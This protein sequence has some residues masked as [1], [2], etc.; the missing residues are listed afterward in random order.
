MPTQGLDEESI[1]NV[2]RKIDSA[3]LRSE[4][5]C[6]VCGRDEGLRNRVEALLRVLDQQ[7]GFLAFPMP[8]PISRI[9]PPLTE[10]PGSVVGPYKLLEQIGEGGF[11][12]VFMAEQTE[13]VRR[14]VALK[15]LKPGMDTRQIVARFEAERQALAIMDHP[16]IA[17]VFDGGETASGRPFFVMELVKGVPITDYCDQ[18]HLTPRERLQLFISVC[19]AVQ[20]AHQK[21]VIH[22]DL[23]ASNVLVAVHDVMPVVKVI[24]FGIAKAIGQ[25]LTEKTLFTGFAHL[26]GTPACMSPEQ[27]GMS[28]LDVDTRSDIYSL[29]VLLYELLTGTTPFDKDRLQHASFDEIRRIIREVEPPN[30]STRLTTLGHADLNTMAQRCSV[31]PR[32]LSQQVRG[33]LDWIV[34]KCLEKDRNRRY[35]TANGLVRDIENY[36]ADQPV[37]ACPP[38]AWYRLRKLAYR[39]KVALTTAALVATTLMLGTSISTWQAIRA[40]RAE[41]LAASR[42]LAE[43]KSRHAAEIAGTAALRESNRATL[44]LFQAK[45]E[46]AK[47]SRR[48]RTI[49]QRF[50]SWRA[51][52]EAAD[53]ARELKMRE[54]HLAELRDE[55]IACLALADLR[56]ARAPWEGL[57]AGSSAGV[58]FDE[59]LERYARSDGQGNVSVRRVADDVELARLPGDHGAAR[60]AFSPSGESLAVICWSP[61]P[62]PNTTFCLWDWQHSRAIFKPSTFVRAMDFSPDGLFIALV[63]LDGTL[64]IH[65]AANGDE[66]FNANLGLEPFK[67]A[68]SFDGSRIAILS[69]AGDVQIRDVGTGKLLRT[70][71]LPAEV[72]HVAWH[73]DGTML[74]AASEDSNVYLLD[75]ATGQRRGV[76]Q[77]HQTTVVDVSFAPGGDMLCTSS[78]DGTTRLWNVWTGREQLRFPGSSLGFSRDGRRLASQTGYD[79]NLWDVALGREYRTLRDSHHPRIHGGGISP[80]GRWLAVAQGGDFRLW[81]LSAGKVTNIYSESAA[82]SAQFHPSG[83]ELFTS[84]SEGLYRWPVRTEAGA[85]RIGPASRLPVAGRTG[86]V[87]LD[88]DGLILATAASHGAWVF[89][90]A[91]L[92]PDRPNAHSPFT[93]RRD[94]PLQTDEKGHDAPPIDIPSTPGVMSLDHGNSQSVAVSPDGQ[95]VAAGTLHGFGVKVWDARR[96]KVAVPIPLV[97]DERNT[98]VNFSPDGKWLV[99]GTMMDFSIWDV[100]SWQLARRIRRQAEGHF[101]CAFTRDG[102]VMAVDVSNGVLLLVDP[103]TGRHLARLEAPEPS[104]SRWLTFTPDN[105][106]IACAG[107][108]PIAVWDLV[109]IRE[110]LSEIGLDW[111]GIPPY[112]R[113]GPEKRDGPQ[114]QPTEVVVDLGELAEDYDA[115]NQTRSRSG[116]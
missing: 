17:K 44:R 41:A 57:P 61:N 46:Q 99:M 48:S 72:R 94:T 80:D 52:T 26:V 28:S 49:G 32:K 74:A 30:P 35:E 8:E 84:G 63:H 95:W 60:I 85:L 29:G 77:G 114:S 58:A 18:N 5:L 11:A 91:T 13:P 79:L 90:L 112:E 93:A 81:D 4:Y 37:Q 109:R 53:L 96:G 102:K 24:D 75:A 34:M 103:A 71:S 56:P 86:D 97:P 55:A 42:L 98:S 73:P 111:V 2:A 64:A 21:G 33:E 100:G 67:L 116:I 78:Y 105:E 47:A 59:D 1:F 113:S 87:A 108:G 38:S 20:H 66:V 9:D 110:Q 12:V 70:L 51:V 31:E 7:K 22:R 83:K 27:A 104:S 92:D 65:R 39:N 14:K 6:Q 76:M 69:Y 62:G 3:D 50:E 19:Q 54:E 106:L 10:R 82:G 15:V 101:G 40:T 89:D 45:L 36:L 43:K 107:L 25:Q 16:H 23:K 115:E 88:R 68:Y